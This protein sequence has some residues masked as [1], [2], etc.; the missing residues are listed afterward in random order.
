[1]AHGTRVYEPPKSVQ[2]EWEKKSDSHSMILGWIKECAKDEKE[3]SNRNK[4]NCEAFHKAL[5]A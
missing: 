2:L 3:L 1:M 5:Q 4:M